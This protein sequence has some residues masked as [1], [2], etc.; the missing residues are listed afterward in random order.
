MI[1]SADRCS[2]GLGE[3][4]EKGNRTTVFPQDSLSKHPFE[5]VLVPKRRCNQ[6]LLP[7]HESL[8]WLNCSKINSTNAAAGN[9]KM[10]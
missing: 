3:N 7:D 9:R 10:D 1:K 6:N 2:Q 8:K 4:L 5:L